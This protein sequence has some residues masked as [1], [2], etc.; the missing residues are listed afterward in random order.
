[1]RVTDVRQN[2]PEFQKRIH[3]KIEIEDNFLGELII[4]VVSNELFWG[5]RSS[6]IKKILIPEKIIPVP[7]AKNFVLGVCHVSGT[8]YTV[9]DFNVLLGRA[10]PIRTAKSRLI[11]FENKENPIALYVERAIDMISES[12]VLEKKP[13]KHKFSDETL[14]V[15]NKEIMMTSIGTLSDM[16]LL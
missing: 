2:L 6:E 10:H 7:G 12:G 16:A 5:F 15:K 8:I 1:M 9:V 4:P 13:S 14:V 3:E 11:C